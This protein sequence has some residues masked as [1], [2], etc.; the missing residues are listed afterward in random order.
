MIQVIQNGTGPWPEYE[1][2]GTVVRVNCHGSTLAIDCAARQ[3]DARVTIDMVR[4]GG[5]LREGAA[6]G[7]S[8]VATLEIPPAKYKEPERPKAPEPDEEE[9]GMM[10]E[11]GAGAE[12]LPLTAE[13]MVTVVL[14][15]WTCPMAG[16]HEHNEQEGE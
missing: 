11:E 8:Y 3:T 5:E 6:G 9:G 2:E 10:F 16:H 15:L 1:E 12:R 13:D 14:R 7:E 4:A